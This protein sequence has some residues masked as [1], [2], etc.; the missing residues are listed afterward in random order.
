MTSFRSR[1]I[2]CVPQTSAQNVS[3][4]THFLLYYNNTI[5]TINVFFYFQIKTCLQTFII[6]FGS[7]FITTLNST[8]VITASYF[9][10][11]HIII[12]SAIYLLCLYDF[13]ITGTDVLDALFCEIMYCVNYFLWTLMSAKEEDCLLF[14]P[15]YML[16]TSDER[17]SLV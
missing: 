16:M 10:T 5:V 14:C 6:I 8:A 4:L 13:C 1:R 11:V 3:F 7:T 15:L 12:F 9:S 2:T 17:K